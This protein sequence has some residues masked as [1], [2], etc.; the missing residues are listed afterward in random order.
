MRTT[1]LLLGAEGFAELNQD[2]VSWMREATDEEVDAFRAELGRG[3]F[4][5]SCVDGT[6][7]P[8]F[9]VV[10]TDEAPAGVWA[11]ARAMKRAVR[12]EE[13]DISEAT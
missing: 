2:G 11:F 8:Y 12:L 7:R 9:V 1:T 10:V 4:D 6:G 3:D 5:E 13:L